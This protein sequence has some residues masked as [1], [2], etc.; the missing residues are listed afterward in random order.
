MSVPEIET[1][2]VLK[3]GHPP[4]GKLTG[5]EGW[6]ARTA[7]LTQFPDDFLIRYKYREYVQK[8]NKWDWSR[9]IDQVTDWELMDDLSEYFGRYGIS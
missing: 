8:D 1:I 9:K 2:I 4:M 7:Y 3:Y 6:Y 5:W